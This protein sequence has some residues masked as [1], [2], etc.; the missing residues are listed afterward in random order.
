MMKHEKAK[1]EEDMY[2]TTEGVDPDNSDKLP[3]LQPCG[4]F[5]LMGMNLGDRVSPTYQKSTLWKNI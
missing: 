5:V 3:A 2:N 4:R 1:K